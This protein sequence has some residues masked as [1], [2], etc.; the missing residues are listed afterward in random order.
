M[1]LCL[2]NG[3]LSYAKTRILR[4]DEVYSLGKWLVGIKTY[5]R[6]HR[7]F[8]DATNLVT[9]RSS[10]GF[11]A[12]YRIFEICSNAIHQSSVTVRLRPK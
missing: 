6:K 8:V 1:V 5:F 12:R 3:L 11:M 2:L 4:S 10:E 9:L 7:V